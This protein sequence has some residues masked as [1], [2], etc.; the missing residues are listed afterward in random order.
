M[1]ALALIFIEMVT[2]RWAFADQPARMLPA[3][4]IARANQLLAE[5]PSLRNVLPD[6]PKGLA[7]L[8]DAA[9]SRDKTKRPHSTQFLAGLR[10]AHRALRDPSVAAPTDDRTEPR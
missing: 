5:P 6:C 7:A 3:R 1:R 8:I 10:E 2:L 4:E 9:L